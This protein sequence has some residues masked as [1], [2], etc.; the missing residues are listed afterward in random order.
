MIA[1]RK[2]CGVIAGAILV[3][4]SSAAVSQEWPT[5]SVQTIS[6]F[7]AGN[8]ND[9]VARIVLDEV[10]RQMGRSFVIENRPGGGGT[11]GA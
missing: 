9:I 10:G 4:G 7:T 6:P 11:L 8:A 5:R 2:F 1:I 3:A